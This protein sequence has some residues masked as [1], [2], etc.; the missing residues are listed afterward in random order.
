MTT[1]TYHG[2]KLVQ[3]TVFTGIKWSQRVTANK[4]Q[5]AKVERSAAAV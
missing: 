1:V 4:G 2:A 5:W 3:V